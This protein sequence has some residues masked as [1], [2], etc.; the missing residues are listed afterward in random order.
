MAHTCR[1]TIN[2]STAHIDTEDSCGILLTS[3]GRSYHLK[4][5][6]E[7]DRQ[8][9]ITALELAKAKAVRVMNTHSGSELLAQRVC[10][11]WCHGSGGSG[12]CKRLGLSGGQETQASLDQPERSTCVRV[13]CVIS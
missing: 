2:L 11:W 5:S 7:V 1:A 9:W 3:G 8:Q 6:S 12:N 13:L 10:T 4:A